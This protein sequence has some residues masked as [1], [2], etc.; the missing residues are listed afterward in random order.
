MHPNEENNKNNVVN[1]INEL[2]LY[3]FVDISN[4][5]VKKNG[6]RGVLKSRRKKFRNLSGK[7]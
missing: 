6:N 4:E 2:H 7:T 1:W 3:V 5:I